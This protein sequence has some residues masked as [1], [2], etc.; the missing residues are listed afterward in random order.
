MLSFPQ[1]E[2]KT[3]LHASRMRRSDENRPPTSRSAP[4]IRRVP[5]DATKRFAAEPRTTAPSGRNILRSPSANA[6]GKIGTRD[7][8]RCRRPA[9]ASRRRLHRTQKRPH[10]GKYTKNRRQP[11]FRPSYLFGPGS[12][13][14]KSGKRSADVSSSRVSRI[15]VPERPCPSPLPT[16]RKGK[17]SVFRIGARPEKSICPERRPDRKDLSS[18]CSCRRG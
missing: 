15:P 13:K 17:P 8:L 3:L 14:E 18:P 16:N 7:D 12:R 4:R 1:I 2:C 6:R 11:T 5:C 10:H 9:D